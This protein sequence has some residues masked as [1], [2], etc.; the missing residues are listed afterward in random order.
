VVRTGYESEHPG[1]FTDAESIAVLSQSA[2]RS[3]GVIFASYETALVF[4][5]VYWDWLF[6]LIGVESIA[7]KTE[8]LDGNLKYFAPQDDSEIRSSGT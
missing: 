6:H 4:R 7:V 8:Y 3:F 1:Q 5:Q 2:N